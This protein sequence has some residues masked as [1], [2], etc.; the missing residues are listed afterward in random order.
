MITKF[1]MASVAAFGMAL[2]TA[3]AI[4]CIILAINVY[5]NSKEES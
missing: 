4:E 3:L 2:F 5:R 1:M